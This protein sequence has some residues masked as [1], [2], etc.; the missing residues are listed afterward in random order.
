MYYDFSKT[1]KWQVIFFGQREEIVDKSKEN[2]I[3]QDF[4]LVSK[5]LILLLMCNQ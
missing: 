2:T 1:S 5:H 3:L 4:Y